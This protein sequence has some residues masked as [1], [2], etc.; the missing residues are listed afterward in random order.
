MPRLPQ[1]KPSSPEV[2]TVPLALLLLLVCGGG[3]FG[4]MVMVF[5]G[6]GMLGLVLV[7]LGL[8]FVGQYYVWGRW[9]YAWAVKKEQQS[10][11]ARDAPLSISSVLPDSEQTDREF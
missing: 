9:L 5:P 3:F 8:F 4:L 10:E 6:A 2:P 11:S 1:K 7:L